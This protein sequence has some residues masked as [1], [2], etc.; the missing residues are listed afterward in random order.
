M[1]GVAAAQDRFVKTPAGGRIRFVTS[2]EG[3]GVPVVFLNSLAADLSMWDGVVARLGDRRTL[4]LDAR[5]HGRSDVVEGTSTIADLGRDALAVMDAAGIERAVICGL[6]LGGLTA[7]WIAGHAPERV[8]GLV[9]AN[10]AVNFP[11]AQMWHDRAAAAR[12]QG[13]EPLVQPTLERWLTEEFRARHP[14]AAEAVRAM[15]ASTPAEGYAAACGVLAEADTTEEL[16]G[17]DGPVL[18]MTGDRDQSTPA[19]RAEEMKALNEGAELLIL[20]GAH[21][22]SVEAADA[23]AAQ[24]MG[25]CE[26]IDG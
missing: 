18:V 11:P 21:L 3:A 13:F 26:R 17:Y 4:R 9:L 16:S 14:E 23:F 5:G 1:D 19:A 12:E 8:A 7:M 6:S 20:K 10:T 2:G 24:L 15:I 25:F 22:S